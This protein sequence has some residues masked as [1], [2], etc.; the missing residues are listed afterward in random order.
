[1][2]EFQQHLAAGQFDPLQAGRRVDDAG[3]VLDAEYL[4]LLQVIRAAVAAPEVA[5]GGHPDFDGSQITGAH[6]AHF[7]RLESHVTLLVRRCVGNG[8][9]DYVRTK[10]TRPNGSSVRK[11][12][13]RY[14]VSGLSGESISSRIRTAVR[15]SRTRPGPGPGR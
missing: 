13:G 15:A 10:P 5:A 11:L 1:N 8:R 12:S 7:Q 9:G 2:I 14:K 3:H 6:L 4:A